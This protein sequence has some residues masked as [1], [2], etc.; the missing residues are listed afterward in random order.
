MQDNFG[1]EFSATDAATIEQ[2]NSAMEQYLDFSGRPIATLQDVDDERFLAGP[3]FCA[4]MKLLDG[5]SPED[6]SVKTD[7]GR[8]RRAKAFAPKDEQA[9]AQAVEYMASGEFARAAASWDALLEVRPNDVLALK[10]SH[11]AWFL[12]G[13][14]ASMRKSSTAAIGRLTADDPVYSIA[15]GQHGFSLEETGDYV[16]AESWARLAMEITPR[17]CWALHCLAHVYESQNRHSEALALLN[18]QKSIWT[19]QNLFSG[20][21]W[22]HLALRHV[23]AHDFSEALAVFDE[24]L[25]DVPACSRFRLTDGTSLLWRLELEGIDVGDRWLSMAE[26]W[27]EHVDV[28]TNGFLNL[29]AAMAFARCPNSRAAS[30]FF[31]KLAE[32]YPHEEGENANTIRNVARPLA[33]AMRQFLLSPQKAAEHIATLLPELHRIGGSVA[34]REVIERSYIKALIERGKLIDAAE[35]LDPKIAANP[36]RPWM[37]RERARVAEAGG[38]SA[39]AQRMEQRANLMFTTA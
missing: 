38:D 18:E 15:A 24:T 39:T 28:H 33:L 26:K 34:Q 27:A 4:T 14:A 20:H 9:H 10:C 3:V 21:I 11:E 29:H 30:L 17:D 37:L 36:N 7:L 23:E 13:N 12:I 25:C 22:W 8:V 2:W 6:A 19:E 5:A 16:H 31:D 1:T 32:G 35:W